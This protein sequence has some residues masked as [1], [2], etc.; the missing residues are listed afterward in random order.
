MRDATPDAVSLTGPPSAVK[1]RWT[2]IDSADRRAVV[3]IS[4]GCRISP[5]TPPTQPMNDPDAA[6][7]LRPAV[8]AA[9]NARWADFGAGTGTFTRALASLLGPGAQLHAVD[10]DARALRAI[11]SWA[12]SHPSLSVDLIHG[13]FTRRMELPPLDGILIANALHFVRDQVASVQLA[14]SYLRPDGRLV[15]IEYEDRAP[16]RWVPYPVS[17]ERLAEIAGAAGLGAPRVVAR[18]PSAYGGEMYVAVAP[19]EPGVHI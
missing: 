18:R 8:P 1:G 6:D 16:S 17:T 15:V 7:L 2:A 13:D 3:R 12:E 19:R 10:A 14:A 4:R 9:P 5:P 11:R